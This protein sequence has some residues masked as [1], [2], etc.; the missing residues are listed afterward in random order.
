MGISGNRNNSARLS[1]AGMKFTLA[2]SRYNS[3]IVDRLLHGAT[4]TLE[5]QGAEA[6]DIELVKV[7]GAFELPLVCQRI[8]AQRH[9]DAIIAIGAVVRGDTPHFDYVAGNCARGLADVALKFDLPVVFGVLTVDTL[10]QALARAGENPQNKGAEAALT[11][12]EM[13]S[14]LAALKTT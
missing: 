4:L 3:D 7:P 8:A 12:I 2:V 10:E 14:V 13:V 1:A 9:C 6:H 11:A 5:R